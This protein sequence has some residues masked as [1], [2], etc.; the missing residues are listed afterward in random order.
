MVNKIIW[1]VS[2]AIYSLIGM[3]A[4]YLFDSDGSLAGAIIGL[5]VGLG[6]AC[7]ALTGETK[8]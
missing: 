7:F 8:S 3:W 2:P 4:C 6:I 1:V 5:I